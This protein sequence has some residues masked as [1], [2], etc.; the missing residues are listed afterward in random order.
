MKSDALIN[1]EVIELTEDERKAGEKFHKGRKAFAWI[2]GKLEFIEEGD[3]RDH[4]HWMLDEFG[5][6][7]AEFETTLRGY[8]NPDKIQLFI[9]S[10]F[11]PLDTDKISVD[12]FNKL[13]HIY[14]ERYNKDTV[15]IY[16]G[17]VIG[18]V[19]DIWPPIYKL[20]VFNT[21]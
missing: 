2:K 16:N 7:P 6:T 18:K 11:R 5:I 10:D 21:I 3:D 15:E 12:D 9:G 1:G 19:G 8:M 13:L 20:G 14:G 4:Q 17:V